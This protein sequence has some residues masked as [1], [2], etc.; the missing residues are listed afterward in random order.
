MTARQDRLGWFVPFMQAYG[1]ADAQARLVVDHAADAYRLG[2][3]TPQTFTG[4]VAV[5]LGLPTPILV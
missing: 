3:I 4:R 1:K 2:L 5:A